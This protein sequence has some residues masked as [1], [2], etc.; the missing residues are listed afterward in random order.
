MRRREFIEL[1]TAT[2]AA[3][4][5]GGCASRRA[6]PDR[7][8]G[9]SLRPLDAAA[10][11]ATRQ[12]ADL[13]PGKIAYL[14]RGTGDAALFL[15]GSPLNGYQWRGA[16]DRLASVRRCVAPDLMGLGYTEVAGDQ[17]LTAAAQATMLAALL[18]RLSIAQVDLIASDS[19]GAAAQWFV[20][21]YPDRVRTML[22]TNC[23]T[24]PD[25]PPEKVKPILAQ[26]RAG[27]LADGIAAWRADKAK[28]RA[29]FGAAVFGDPS[30]LAD[31]TIEYYFAPIVSSAAHRTW[32]HDYHI[33][34]DPN[35]LAGIEAALRRCQ[36]PTR[37]VWGTGDDIFSQASPDYLARTLP[38]SR[39]VR[40]LPGAKLFF[41]EEYPDVI[42]D[43]A[44]RLW[45]VTPQSAT[46]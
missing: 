4:V 38:G 6:A 36:V 13:P 25:S 28:A 5:V 39:G 46:G 16:I 9:P 20:A 17:P 19:G 12:T 29:E 43:E 45:G 26:A 23:D 40:R 37:I 33:A 21:R 44:R 34:M 42:A 24:E 31:E 10:Y 18:D 8:A 35:P 32:F 27:T 3:G 22:L 11:R 15:H 41:Q 30:R 2:L 1:A 7:A 14:E